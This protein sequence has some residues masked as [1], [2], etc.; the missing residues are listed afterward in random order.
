MKIEEAALR[1][2][3]SNIEQSADT[4]PGC[5][6]QQCSHFP[7]VTHYTAKDAFVDNVKS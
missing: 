7:L 6:Q 2:V 3:D 5:E 4:I 1:A